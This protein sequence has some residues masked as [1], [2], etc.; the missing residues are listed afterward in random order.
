MVLA[1][2]A[3]D[4]SR[5]P[6]WGAYTVDEV[7]VYHGALSPGRIQAHYDAGTGVRPAAARTGPR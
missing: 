4:R 5:G 3:R 2:G 7:A 6:E 1:V